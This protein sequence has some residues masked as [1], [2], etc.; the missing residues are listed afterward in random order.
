MV[1]KPL[2]KLEGAVEACERSAASPTELL[3]VWP[4]LCVY[5]LEADVPTCESASGVLF[6]IYIRTNT[7]ESD[8]LQF[9]NSMNIK[10]AQLVH[11]VEMVLF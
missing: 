7:Y 5:C 11:T 3:K 6:N 4:P 9:I 8:V 1:K 10:L 2:M